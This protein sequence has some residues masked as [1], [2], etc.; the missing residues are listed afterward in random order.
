M[1]DKLSNEIEELRRDDVQGNLSLLKKGREFLHCNHSL[2]T[3][4][5]VRIIPNICRGP[6]KSTQHFPDET[7]EHKKKLCQEN[8][9][10]FKVYKSLKISLV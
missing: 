6:G 2:L 8:L 10:V 7:I 4:L 1:V 5:R 3:E 9:A